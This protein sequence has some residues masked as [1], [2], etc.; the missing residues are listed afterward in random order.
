MDKI[1]K[2]LKE[3][4]V[5]VKIENLK[6]KSSIKMIKKL[7]NF[8]I[9]NV[10]NMSHFILK[11]EEIKLVPTR[12]LI[13]YLEADYIL[14]SASW[15]L[16][17]KIEEKLTSALQQKIAFNPDLEED[18]H[19]K[20][21][22]FKNNFKGS[23][24]QIKNN[25]NK[26]SKLLNNIIIEHY[27]VFKNNKSLPK[28]YN[29]IPPFSKYLS[30]ISLT[31]KVNILK[32][33]KDEQKELIMTKFDK[34]KDEKLIWIFSQLVYFRNFVA[35]HD[36]LITKKFNIINE[37]NSQENVGIQTFLKYLYKLASPAETKKFK[38]FLKV[39]SKVESIFKKINL[40]LD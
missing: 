18:F 34:K 1:I 38:S 28:K 25:K 6:S 40:D 30:S 35:H 22:N 15:I 13:E 17:R 5:K 31:K 36:I 29:S 27:N 12:K 24:K 3:N 7:L 8:D 10:I 16:I 32:F 21:S 33:L 37:K 20:I 39:N 4:N 14:K 26:L 2:L 19:L 23:K 11:N 9:K